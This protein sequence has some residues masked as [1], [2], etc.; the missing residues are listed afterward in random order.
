MFLH[1]EFASGQ[2]ADL[3]GRDQSFTIHLDGDT[4]TQTGTLSNGKAL[5]EQWKRIG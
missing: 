3:I 1:M 5:S 2:I 4:F